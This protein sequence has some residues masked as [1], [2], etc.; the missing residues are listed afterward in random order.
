MSDDAKFER[1]PHGAFIVDGIEVGH[2]LQCPHC[3]AQFLSVR[4]S[5]ARRAYCMNCA[6]VTCGNP[7]CD[8]CLPWEKQMEK[9]EKAHRLSLWS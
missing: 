9:Q 6:A 1:K 5:G 8:A 4:G 3:G 7:A 2:T